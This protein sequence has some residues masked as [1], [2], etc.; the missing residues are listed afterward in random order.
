MTEIS[1]VVT[2][3]NQFNSTQLNVI[4]TR[5]LQNIYKIYLLVFYSTFHFWQTCKRNT[6]F[7]LFCLF[8]LKTNTYYFNAVLLFI[9]KYWPVYMTEIN[10][11]VSY[12]VCIC[13]IP[14][15][16]L[17]VRTKNMY[18]QNKWSILSSCVCETV[19]NRT[20]WKTLVYNNFTVM[21]A[22][23]FNFHW[24]CKTCSKYIFLRFYHIVKLS[25]DDEVHTLENGMVNI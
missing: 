18:S 22:M 14:S 15:M 24:L 19:H 1:S 23:I 8:Y 12:N 5:I 9:W 2:L 25:R 17:Y 3:N 7:V 10:L 20:F 13:S 21:F 4:S 16:W 11:S 6:S